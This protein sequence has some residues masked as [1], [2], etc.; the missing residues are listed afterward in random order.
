DLIRIF[1]NTIQLN[2][3]VF[4]KKICPNRSTCVLKKEIDSIEQDV[5]KRLG[6][7]SIASLLNGG[8]GSLPR[9]KR[10]CHGDCSSSH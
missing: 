1:Q 8:N 10:K 5:F 3:C 7:I 4:K 2:E 6:G 9:K